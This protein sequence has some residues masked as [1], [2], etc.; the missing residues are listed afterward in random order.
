MSAEK[1][2]GGMEWASLRWIWKYQGSGRMWINFSRLL[3]DLLS[4][5]FMVSEKGI[6]FFTG[7]ISQFLGLCLELCGG[8]RERLNGWMDN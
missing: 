6:L 3:L 5:F 7:L 2:D 8:R 4:V 1:C